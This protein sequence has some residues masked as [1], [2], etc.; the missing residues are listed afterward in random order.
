MRVCA[1]THCYTVTLPPLPLATPA[2][3]PSSQADRCGTMSDRCGTRR[4]THTEQAD[5]WRFPARFR[6]I[7]A[8]FLL[9][10]GSVECLPGACSVPVIQAQFPL[11]ACLV[12]SHSVP[13]RLPLDP[14]PVP[15]R[16]PLGASPA[17]FPCTAFLIIIESPK[18][19]WHPNDA[20]IAG[21][22]PP[23]RTFRAHPFASLQVVQLLQ[24]GD[25]PCILTGAILEPILLLIA[26]QIAVAADGEVQR[27]SRPNM[28][29]FGLSRIYH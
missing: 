11:G 28:H 29:T 27:Q 21:I 6:S 19:R 13:A 25:R 8:Q 15:A 5:L 26:K 9:G 2:P 20:S 16:F 10:A 23:P 4:C 12:E 17:R 7:Q 3:A 14:G 24:R 22:P 18:L 1:R